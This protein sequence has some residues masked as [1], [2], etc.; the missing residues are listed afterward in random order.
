MLSAVL[1]AS[2]AACISGNRVV[3]FESVERR[4]EPTQAEYQAELSTADATIADA[5]RV[6]AQAPSLE[7]LELALGLSEV[8]VLS[9]VNE[10]SAV[11][12]PPEARLT[13]LRLLPGLRLFAQDLSRVGQEVTTG[14]ICAASAALVRIGGL[15][16]VEE[17]RAVQTAFAANSAPSSYQF[18]GSL[19]EPRVLPDRRPANGEMVLDRRGSGDGIL[20]ISNTADLPAVVT[21]AGGARA[22]ASIYV[23]DG[24]TATLDGIAGATYAVY[25]TTGADWDPDLDTFTRDCQFHKVDQPFDFTAASRF[26]LEL[27]ALAATEVDPASYPRDLS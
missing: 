7:A 14:Q 8:A 1:S 16:G 2:L 23:A 24:E 9:V 26:A 19:P 12:S 13:H 6:I 21:L 18:G 11:P 17:L 15:E 3:E 22:I 5:M 25:Y 4:T 10:L 20:E 27:E